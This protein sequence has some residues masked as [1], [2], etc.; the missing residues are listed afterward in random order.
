MTTRCHSLS[1]LVTRCHFLYLVLPFLVTL[2]T[3]RCHSLSLVVTRNLS[4]AGLF[5]NDLLIALVT[6]FNKNFQ[7][8]F[9]YNWSCWKIFVIKASTFY[10]SKLLSKRILTRRETFRSS[11]LVRPAILIKQSPTQVFFFKFGEIFKINIEHL[12]WLLLKYF[13]YM[14]LLWSSFFQKK[15]KGNLE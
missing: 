2:C 12:W 5:K 11:H 9:C 4:F 3:P 14:S 10:S 6:A 7:K 8:L 1:F 13:I 15:N